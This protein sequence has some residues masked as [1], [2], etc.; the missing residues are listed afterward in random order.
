MKAQGLGP[1]AIARTF[2]VT[3]DAVYRVLHKAGLMTRKLD[4]TAP[5]R[6]R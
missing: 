6:P 1:G 3:P 5:A 4:L 2:G